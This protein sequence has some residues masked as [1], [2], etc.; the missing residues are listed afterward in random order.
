ME[1]IR[2]VNK[3]NGE[4]WFEVPSKNIYIEKTDNQGWLAS[5]GY[6]RGWLSVSELKELIGFIENL[7]KEN[8]D[9]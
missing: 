1:L 4:L 9:E 5:F 2:H 8:K 3:Y 6:D 7:E